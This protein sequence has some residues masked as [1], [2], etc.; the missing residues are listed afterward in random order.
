MLLQ[1]YAF[2]L[3][4]W[5]IKYHYFHYIETSQ[6]VWFLSND[7][8]IDLSPVQSSVAFHIEISHLICRAIQITGFSMKCNTGLKWVK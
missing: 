5:F 7:R 3:F 1:K 4:C 6:F 2:E 8:N